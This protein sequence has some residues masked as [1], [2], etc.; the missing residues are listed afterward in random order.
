MPK[1]KVISTENAPSAVGPYSQAIIANGFIFISGQL[2]IDPVTGNF[3]G[4]D[5][6]TQF[7]QAL[8]NLKSILN[9][10]NLTLDNVVKTT[11]FLTDINEFGLINEV[12]ANYFKNILPAR[13]A[14]EVSKLPKGARVEVEAIA[15]CET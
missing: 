6:R 9:S 11:V 12:Y 13:S 5:T 3:A 10:V 8:K 7:D 2:G 14:I 15:S 1:L 4:E